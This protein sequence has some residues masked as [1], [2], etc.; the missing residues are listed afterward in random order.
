MK[1][2]NIN[3]WLIKDNKRGHDKQSESLANAIAKITDAEITT[4]KEGSVSSLIGSYIRGLKKVIT[5]KP[6]FI[7][8]AG[9]STHFRMILSKILYGG[10][11]IVIMKPSL[12]MTCF[13]LNIIPVHDKIRCKQNVIEINGSLNDID[14]EKQ[15]SSDVGLILLGGESKYFIWDY[16]DITA[17]INKIIKYNPDLKITISNSRRTPKGFISYLKQNIPVGA[18]I[19][20]YEKVSRDW[21]DKQAKKSKYAWVTEDSVSMIYELIASG[22]Q[23]TPI[24]LRKKA[25]SKISKEVERLINLKVIN[26]YG[27]KKL[28]VKKIKPI[29]EAKRCAR[30]ILDKWSVY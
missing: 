15:H 25:K 9:H 5:K 21:L 19:I 10:K 27:A 13:D 20:L 7:I 12:P 11:T 1:N 6:D 16:A 22:S 17:Q 18:E 2:K 28:N 3:I 30:M 23:V 29:N 24:M 26:P 14:N 4:M 8:G